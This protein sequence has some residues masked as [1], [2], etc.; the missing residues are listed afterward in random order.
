MLIKKDIESGKFGDRIKTAYEN[1]KI[2]AEKDWHARMIFHMINK[3]GLDNEDFYIIL[4][5][6]KSYEK[7]FKLLLKNGYLP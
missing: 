5:M 3:Y 1:I 6:S 7:V 4:S 2:A